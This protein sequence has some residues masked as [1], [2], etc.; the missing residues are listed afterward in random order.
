M[1]QGRWHTP[2]SSF[3]LRPGDIE[4]LQ[5]LQ[6]PPQESHVG[7]GQ[8]GI[9]EPGTDRVARRVQVLAIAIGTCL[10]Q[11]SPGRNI[12]RAD[13]ELRDPPP[14]KGQMRGIGFRSSLAAHVFEEQPHE[15]VAI[16][17]KPV[18][19][20]GC[21]G[22]VR[23]DLLVDRA[24]DRRPRGRAALRDDGLTP[25]AGARQPIRGRF[26][27]TAQ[28]FDRVGGSGVSADGAPGL[29][30]RVPPD[31]AQQDRPPGEAAGG[32][33]SGDRGAHAVGHA[34]AVALASRRPRSSC[35]RR[36]QVVSAR[37]R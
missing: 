19:A 29:S 3:D 30:G 4:T 20:W 18:V 14:G 22:H 12:A 7:R 13:V 35:R 27:S 17:A 33:R 28:H 23:Q 8:G 37:S 10:G 11:R 2:T 24:F 26:F 21:D 25:P 1:R 15:P 34:M 31:V 6:Q 16:L 36:S 9:R 32:S 5:A